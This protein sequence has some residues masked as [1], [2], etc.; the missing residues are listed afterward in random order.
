MWTGKW[1]PPFRC[2]NIPSNAAVAPV[3]I[4]TDKTQLTQL[5]GSKSAYPN[6]CII[7]GY[8]SVDKIARKG[9]SKQIIKTR[10]QKLFHA[11]M[12]TI[13]QPLMEAGMNGMD[14]TGGDGAVRRVFPILSSY[15]TDYPEQCLAG[16]AK[17]G[18]CPKCQRSATDLEDLRG[19][20]Y[21]ILAGFPL[22]NIASSLTLDV[23]HQLF[24]GVLNTLLDVPESHDPD[25]L[26][27]RIRVLPPAFGVRH[28]SKGISPLSQISGSERKAMARI[29]LDA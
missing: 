28:F 3:I 11:S 24:Q 13:L 15:V 29:Y 17:Y 16:C 9:L 6:A 7:L 19:C 5:S 23:L 8:L 14:V 26:D 27:A 10:N 21:P 18:T 4:A 1:W 12:R 2:D 25:E 20:S 22:T